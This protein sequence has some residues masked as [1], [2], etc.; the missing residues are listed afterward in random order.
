L[1]DAYPGIYDF[2]PFRVDRP[3][4]LLLRGGEPVR[5]TAKAFDILLLLIEERGRLVSKD[6]LMRRVWPDAVVEE[7]NLTVNISALRKALGESPGERRCVATVP[8]RGYQFVAEVRAP[9]PPILASVPPSPAA[10]R[11]RPGGAL[12]GAGAL[13]AAAIAVAAWVSRPSKSIHGGAGGV[14]AVAVLPF[15]NVGGDE[16]LDYLSD[17]ITESLINS[18]SQLP[19]VKVIAR[20]SAFRYKGMKAEPGEVAAA[21]GVEAVVTGRVVRREEALSISVELV[22]AGTG[23]QAWGEHYD[24]KA[25]DLVAVQSE[26]SAAI[27]E[28]LRLR[29]GARDRGQ[30]D[31]NARVDPRAY[32]LLLQGR[33]HFNK[34]SSLERKKAIDY[35]R[36]AT[37]AD[38]TYAAAYAELAN[39]YCL[40]GHD[41]VL[42]QEEALGEAEAAARR[43]LALDD[44]LAEAHRALGFRRQLAWEWAGAE[45]EYRRAIELNPNYA[46]AHAN[47]S[48]FLSLLGRHDQAVAEARRARELD[49]MSIATN[50]WVFTTL[51]Y[52]RRYD[53]ARAVV[54]RMRELD[55]NHPLTWLDLGY[56][57]SARGR[58]GDAVK[59]FEEA[60]RRGY[61]D[62]SS[63]VYLGCAYARAGRR[64]EAQTL[65]DGLRKTKEYVSP[66]ELAALYASLGQDDSAL[67]SLEKACSAHDIQLQY[68]GVDPLLDGL[69]SDPRFADVMRRV[70]LP[71]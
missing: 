24:R 2:G 10:A 31:R 56:L 29:L 16:R 53:E 15:T 66:A 25:A 34:G 43:A 45:T 68:L 62:A 37:A 20:S 32:E 44:G 47:Y 52:A 13:L 42:G 1:S 63:R 67:A 50:A 26:I 46:D 70:G 12:L 38:P 3:R 59:A 7:N 65:L 33:F 40:L 41:G 17:G 8:G 39:A 21:L 60:S 9:E 48:T 30:I 6:E 61:Q 28:Q 22:D 49:P 23:T 19:G 18:L 57:E 55:P 58:D 5:L 14:R 11:W 54:V 64:R 4:R 51:L 27:A 36:Q 69:R 35:Y 71:P